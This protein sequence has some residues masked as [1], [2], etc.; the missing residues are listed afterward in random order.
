MNPN[1]THAD[2]ALLRSGSAAES[3]AAIHVLTLTP[4]FPSAA[5]EAGGC[6]IAEPLGQLKQQNVA[7]SVIAVSPL[8]HPR[9][10]PA[11]S[12]PA[13]WVRYPQIPG[14]LGLASAGR[15]LYARLLGRVRRM[16]RERPIDLIHA[17]AALPCGHAAMLL[18]RHLNIPFVVTVHGL[19]VFN[20]CYAGGM[21]AAWRRKVSVDVYREAR[22]VICISQKVQQI[23]RDGMAGEVRSAVVYN[24]VNPRRF[25]PGTAPVEREEKEIV[26]VGNLIASKGHELALKACGRLKS[27]DL[28]V[29]CLIIGDGPERAR[30]SSLAEALGIAQQVH[31]WG[32]KSRVEVAEAMRGCSVFVLPSSNEGLGCVYLEAMACGKPVIA[33]QGQGIDEVIQHG[34]NGWL[35]PVAGLEEL[36]EGLSALLHSPELCARIGMA[37]RETILN[38]LTLSHQAQQLAKVYAEAM[39]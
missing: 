27:S 4:F 39:A 15:L 28:K 37:A 13:A 10:A 5:D 29:R 26:M 2:D 20:T 34:K 21:P 24:G 12:T 38:R 35:I 18:S 22:T 11:P 7:S 32:R 14:N 30:L 25:S 16:Q 6:F 8:H 19:D 23:L 17:H 3:A 1:S 36:V 31:F 33:C 9:K